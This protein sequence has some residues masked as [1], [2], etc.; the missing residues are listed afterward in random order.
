MSKNL[1][2]NIIEDLAH[3]GVDEKSARVYV[4]LLQKGDTSAITISK[5]LDL[6]RQ[7]IY[8]ALAS[9]KEKG[10]VVHIKGIR[11]KWRAQH[12]RAFIAL[13]EEQELRAKKV[14]ETLAALKGKG[15]EQEFSVTE[16]SKGFQQGIIESIRRTPEGATVRLI[17]GE[18]YRYYDL[19]GEHIH[20]QWDEIRLA[21]NITFRIIGPK[22][23]AKG[24]QEAVETR[25]LTEYRILENLDT[26]LVNT[27]IYHDTVD[28]DIYGDPHLTFS[29]KNP[30]VAESQKRFFDTLWE[31]SGT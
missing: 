2:Q 10:L 11:S 23:L 16:G 8:N 15:A 31:L 21:K 9:L 4:F 1:D 13:A 18:W 14:T 3:L 20:T 27:V 12:P 26:N 25:G 30:A 6:H 19:A 24:M 17:C 7:F 28:F 22:S 29:I 5:Q